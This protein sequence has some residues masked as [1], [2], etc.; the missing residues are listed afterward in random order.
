MR[1]GRF[2]LSNMR[3]SGEDHV[4]SSSNGDSGGKRFGP[5]LMRESKGIVQAYPAWGMPGK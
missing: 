3:N 4:G 1:E 2:G 5:S